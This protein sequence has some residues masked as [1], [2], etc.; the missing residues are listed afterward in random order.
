M[1]AETKAFIYLYDLPK[2]IVTSVMISDVIRKAC[3][4]ELTEPVEFKVARVSNKYGI[5]SPLIDGIIKVDQKDLTT[6]AKSIK[7]FEITDGEKVWPCRALPF[8]KD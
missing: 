1:I 8:D 5:P 2:M 4:Y 6:I 7:Y 3:A